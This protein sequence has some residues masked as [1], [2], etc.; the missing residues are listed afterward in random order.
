MGDSKLKYSWT[1]AGVI[2]A[3]LLL[4]AVAFV[5]WRANKPYHP[6]RQPVTDQLPA[7]TT[8]ADDVIVSG[9]IADDGGLA[10]PEAMVFL[11]LH[12]GDGQTLWRLSRPVESDGSFH[13]RR[14]DLPAIPN[15]Y[16]GL[17]AAEAPNYL[18]EKVN[19][20]VN[21]VSPPA[22]TSASPAPSTI[23]P[24]TV[25]QTTISPQRIHLRLVAYSPWLTL[26]L[27]IPA[28]FGL[29][30][31]VLHLT[32]FVRGLWVTYW[33]AIG[34]TVLWGL[35][36]GA[37]VFLYINGHGLIPLFWSDLFVSSGIIIF[38]FIGNV[39]YVAHS[40]HEKGRDF[41][42]D[43]D[44]K[45]R[46]HVLQTLGGRILV[47]P[48]IALAAYGI[49]AATFPNL[50]SGAFAAFFG[51]FTGL[52]IKPVLEALNDIGLRLLS[53]EERIKVAAQATRQD[54]SAP[55]TQTSTT[56]VMR[57]EQA[58]LDAVAAARPE[59]L[60]KKGVIGV[61]SGFKSTGGNL[62]GQRAIIV[63][64]YEKE[65]LDPRDRVPET[66][67][68]FPTDVVPLPPADPNQPCRRE[69]FNLS[70]E[71]LNQDNNASLESAGNLPQDQPV[72]IVGQV[73]VLA[74]PSVF[75]TI[76]SDNQQEFDAKRA[77]QAVKTRAGD[78][79]DFVAFII[80]RASGLPFIGN[81]NVPV[82]NDVKGI[83]HYKG[84]FY[85][86]RGEWGTNKLLACQVLSLRSPDLRTY[87]HELAHSWCA[88]VTFKDPTSQTNHS[89]ELLM[90]QDSQQGLYHWGEAFDDDRSCMDY[91][92]IEWIANGNGTFTRKEIS[93]DS[94]FNYCPLD[95]Y[96]MGLIPHSQVGPIRILQNRQLLD[97]GRNIYQA[98][99][100]TI[101]I[102]DVIASC[103]QRS[104]ATSARNFRQALVVVSND[105][106]SGRA[107]AQQIEDDFRRN[108][109]IQFARATGGLATLTTTVT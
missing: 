23:P 59:F 62:T 97:P 90:V 67:M 101:G 50:R 48:Y 104:P 92:L 38:A 14:K 46:T 10:I 35:I 6:G 54:A 26:V 107:F 81:Y 72:A 80:D 28:I 47:A 7:G 55:P 8:E 87:L 37:L 63:Y 2:C 49:F 79:F 105:P 65:E 88:Y 21:I 68:G 40:L 64:V 106:D 70:W 15:L 43:A 96:L 91:D 99:V 17:I 61:D 73:L 39:T 82:H 32:Q 11:S 52:W 5:V 9:T 51:F 109:E 76:N 44:E 108:Y 94:D 4:A 24:A 25:Q 16:A 66:F 53:V 86:V 93:Q 103:G 75:F 13:F 42:F 3:L 34:T 71:K 60:Q 69:V 45:T 56:D 31:A 33:Y 74:D 85:S 100:K 83:E 22:I 18:A 78:K 41:F 36:V 102:E 98:T 12:N 1:V 19:V 29:F 89:T 77:F 30:F 20:S 84:D 95:R 58:F 27:L 57:P